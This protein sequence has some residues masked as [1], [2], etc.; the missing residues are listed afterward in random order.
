MDG[1]MIR[2]A[3]VPCRT[4][5]VRPVWR[6]VAMLV[7]R[8]GGGRVHYSH[9]PSRH[10]YG[11]LTI[12]C[13]PWPPAM[14]RLSWSR[15]FMGGFLGVG[16]V[17]ASPKDSLRP[18]RLP[19]VSLGDSRPEEGGTMSWALQGSVGPL[20]FLR[21]KGRRLGY[22]W[23]FTPTKREVEKKGEGPTRFLCWM[24]AT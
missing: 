7:P 21:A 22:P 4:G 24:H 6:T 20:F 5:D 3:T 10:Y 13:G 14:G 8:F 17:V 2:M 18:G 16:P 15:S 11:G 23:A 19:L 1:V 12:G 9:V